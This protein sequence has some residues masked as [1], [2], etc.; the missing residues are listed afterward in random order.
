MHRLILALLVVSACGPFK[1]NTKPKPTQSESEE[2]AAQ[3]AIYQPLV[4]AQADSFGVMRMGGSVGDSALFSCLARVS[5]ALTFDPMVFF[6][7][8]KPVR[9][10]LIEPSVS[11]TP[12]SKDMVNGLLWC[13]YDVGRKGDKVKTLEMTNA[14]IA[15]GRAHEDRVLGWYFCTEQDR[16]DYK[17]SDQ[18]WLGRCLMVPSVIKD[19]YRVHKWAG[20]ACDDDCRFWSNVGV[21]VT[22]DTTG[23]ERHLMVLTIT[24]NG[25]VDGAIDGYS[26]DRLRTAADQQP[27]NALYQAAY[28]LFLDGNQERAF[29]GLLDESLF[30]TSRLPTSLEYCTDYLF[31]RDQD[32][33]DWVPCGDGSKGADGRG[34]DWLFAGTVAL[35]KLTPPTKVQLWL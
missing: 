28:H 5:G 20:G 19:I 27:R 11:A 31:Q 4:S 33:K 30:P 14:M 13:A 35:G 21:G 16:T 23:F 12:V 10:P 6:V 29:T 9:H 3:F 1:K 18:N 8:G 7:E 32:A 2:V 26:L 22:T 34:V 17:I 15:F 25:L 24:R